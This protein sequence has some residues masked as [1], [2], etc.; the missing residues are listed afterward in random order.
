M[1]KGITDENEDQH[2]DTQERSSYVL[3]NSV[4]NAALYF[5]RAMVY[6]MRR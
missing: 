3:L 1:A 5:R 4:E 2:K 6:K